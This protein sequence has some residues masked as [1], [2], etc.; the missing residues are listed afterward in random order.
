MARAGLQVAAAAL[1]KTHPLVSFNLQD[2][3]VSSPR[4]DS[5]PQTPEA[6]S[7]L[8]DGGGEKGNHFG[9]LPVIVKS[10]VPDS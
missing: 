8:T 6:W 7:F 3:Y 1:G 2:P 9:L 4:R 5:V 10:Q